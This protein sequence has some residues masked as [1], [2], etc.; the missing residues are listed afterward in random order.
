MIAGVKQP[1]RV[2]V[3]LGGG[4]RAHRSDAFVIEYFD[5]GEEESGASS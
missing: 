4:T 2:L 1:S 3:A 5:A